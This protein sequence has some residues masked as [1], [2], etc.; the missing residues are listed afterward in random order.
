VSTSD[1]VLS[2][3]IAAVCRRYCA[4]GR[5]EHEDQAVAE[6]REL[7]GDR[8]DLL[9][10]HAGLAIGGAGDNAGA[11]APGYLAEAE[12]CKLSGAR[13][14]LIEPWIEVGKKRAERARQRPYTG[15]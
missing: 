2:A 7:A 4:R 9:S 3:K 8:A 10:Q 15:A 14:E 13:Q 12:L 1:Q 5:I 6:L 11:Q